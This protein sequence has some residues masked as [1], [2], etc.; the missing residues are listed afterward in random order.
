M[1]NAVVALVPDSPLLRRRF[2]LYRSGTTDHAGKFWLQTITPGTYKLFSWDYADTD[3][4]QDAQF[5]QAYE[6]SGRTIT[7]REGSTQDVQLRMIPTRR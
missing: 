5:L 7:I 1:A 6:T 3:A 2:D 4:W